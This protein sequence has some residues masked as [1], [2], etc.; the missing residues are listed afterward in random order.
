[1]AMV[2]DMD[3]QLLTPEQVADY[4]QVDRTTVYRYIR[5]GKLS[6]FRI[7]R[8]Y[9]IL[10]ESL[11]LMMKAI[12]TR[13]QI[14]LREYTDEEIKAFLKADELDDEAREIVESFT[15]MMDAHEQQ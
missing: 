3:R 6:A 9:R 7:G 8:N 14:K 1:M 11:D 10:P 5:D 2:A 4:M 13:P 15:R 12:S